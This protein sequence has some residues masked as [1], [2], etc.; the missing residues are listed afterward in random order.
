[1]LSTL[2]GGIAA[3]AVVATVFWASAL[4]AL[5]DGLRVA[6][7]EDALLMTF[8][9]D[10]SLSLPKV[11]C[12]DVVGEADETDSICRDRSW[13]LC[14]SRCLDCDL[15]VGILTDALSWSVE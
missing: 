14:L 11:G 12:V 10:L 15:V 7:L 3:L 8:E 2:T 9:G 6:F 4:G 5:K 13:G 1:M